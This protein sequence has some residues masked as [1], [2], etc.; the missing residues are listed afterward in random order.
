MSIVD[1]YV[2]A[3]EIKLNEKI[4]KL[5]KTEFEKIREFHAKSYDYHMKIIKAKMKKKNDE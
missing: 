4:E 1:L 3:H 2:A 5:H